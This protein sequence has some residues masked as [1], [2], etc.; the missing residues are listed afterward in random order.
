MTDL[1]DAIQ[2]QKEK[3]ETLKRAFDCESRADFNLTIKYDILI[4]ML[5]ES[6]KLNR[7]EDEYLRQDKA[8]DRIAE[9]V[10]AE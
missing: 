7:M 2:D 4:L 1:Y 5:Q 3:V 6:A 9:D 8:L 10:Y